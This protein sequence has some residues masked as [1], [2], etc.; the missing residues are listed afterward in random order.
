M[1]AKP[2]TTVRSAAIAALCTAGCF[3]TAAAQTPSRDAGFDAW[4]ARDRTAGRRPDQ[5]ER[6]ARCQRARTD[7]NMVGE[8]FRGSF[9]ASRFAARVGAS[10]PS[11]PRSSFQVPFAAPNFGPSMPGP[12]AP[13]EIRRNQVDAADSPRIPI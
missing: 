12:A 13:S 8:N 6:N 11:P 1:Q 2:Y 7:V 3:A 5:P 10:L 9:R 4:L